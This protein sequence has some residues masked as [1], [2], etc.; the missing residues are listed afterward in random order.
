[1]LKGRSDWLFNLRIS[2]LIQFG[3]TRAEFASKNIVIVAGLI[4]LISSFCLYYITVQVFT[5][6][7]IHL[8]VG[9]QRGAVWY[10]Q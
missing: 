1:M 4:E 3:A 8:R 6:T 10:R 7:T 9:G 5:K 2:F